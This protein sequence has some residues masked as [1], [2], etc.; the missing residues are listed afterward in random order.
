MNL[1]I[2]DDN[3]LILDVET[4][5]D[6]QDAIVYDIGYILLNRNT[7]TIL[8]EQ[9]FII[10]D[11]FVYERELIKQAYY[12]EKIPEYVK[13]IQENKRTMID[14]LT[15]RRR[16]LNA[17]SQHN[18]HTVAAYNCNF[19]RKALNTTLRFLTK[20]KYRWFFPYNTN[21]ICIWNMACDT[22]CQTSQYKTF[23]ET[24]RYYSNYGKNYRATAEIVYQFITNNTNFK[25]EHKGLDDV[26]IEKE[27]LQKCLEYNNNF[28]GIDKFCW[29]K[30]T[31]GAL[32]LPVIFMLNYAPAKILTQI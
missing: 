21:F 9:S 24:L 10:R 28:K 8:D 1:N 12:C 4:A 18:C 11:T 32:M 3:I 25:E 6:T 5:N 20:S 17:M 29:K 19:D 31:R 2:T 15:A 23:A 27:I 13:D 30:V 14:F 26:K 7:N 22:I 16:I